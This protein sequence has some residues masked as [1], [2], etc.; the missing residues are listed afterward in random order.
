M[1]S[2]QA[3]REPSKY[4][5]EVGDALETMQYMKPLYTIERA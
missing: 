4:V 2:C 3:E 5:R 1:A